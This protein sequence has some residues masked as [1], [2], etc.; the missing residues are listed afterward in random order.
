MDH[1]L[2]AHILVVGDRKRGVEQLLRLRNILGGVH[3]WKKLGAA[4][5][6]IAQLI[7]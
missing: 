1:F 5:S 7:A 6:N 4:Q 2:H 3:P